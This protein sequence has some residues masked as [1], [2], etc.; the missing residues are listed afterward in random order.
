[1]S[2]EDG[3]PGLDR[4][5]GVPLD[6]AV[7]RV[8]ADTGRDPDAV[9]R[10]LSHVTDDEGV[11]STDAVDDALAH[12][13]K[14]VST[15]ETR[16]EFAAIELSDAREAAEP[17]ADVDTVA[18]RLDA[19]E[20]RL[21]AVEARV[22]DLGVELQRLV[23]GDATDD[24]FE[25]AAAIRD[26]TETANATQRAAD[27]LY[28]DA[29]EFQ[30]WLATPVARYDEFASELDALDESLDALAGTV[31]DL[32]D[33]VAGG[34]DDAAADV[35]ADDPALGWFEAT[36]RHRAVGLL[37][38]DL[39]AELADLH[40]LAARDAAGTTADSDDDG[41]SLDDLDDRL[42]ALERRWHALDDRLDDLARR[43]WHDR[44]ADQLRA[45]DAA[46]DPF[47]PPIDWTDVQAALDD[48]REDVDGLA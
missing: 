29:E 37:L 23:D 10:A 33:A 36:L 44:F 46:L 38:A 7:D 24:L 27:E 47:E 13:S 21:D 40:T 42:D 25:T 18:A 43:R 32:A 31:D 48:V 19:F 14:V 35:D 39:R 3:E 9:R 30:R 8:V 22:A 11:V 6:D 16:A 1:M 41:A 5:E 34:T 17:V 12:L 26:L 4:I 2:P 45:L 28:V 15:P 20:S